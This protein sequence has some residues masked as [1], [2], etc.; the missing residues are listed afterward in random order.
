[1]GVFF[2][3]GKKKRIAGAGWIELKLGK[4]RRMFLTINKIFYIS[5]KSLLTGYFM[6]GMMVPVQVSILPLFIILRNL[7]LLNKLSGLILVYISGISMS[8]LIF[9]KFF[10]TI[11]AA[12]EESAI[13]SHLLFIAM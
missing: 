7:G 5:D 13:H 2:H 9:Q 3:E 11:P 8:C 10:R 4:F 1:M 12:L 6:I